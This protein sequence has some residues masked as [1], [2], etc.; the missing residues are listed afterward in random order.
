VAGDDVGE[1]A[2][3]AA[4]P[5]PEI[6]DGDGAGLAAAAGAGDG[7]AVVGWPPAGASGRAVAVA[8]AVVAGVLGGVIQA[9]P[10]RTSVVVTRRASRLQRSATRP[11]HRFVPLTISLGS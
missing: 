10:M 11:A 3:D 8:G 7:G 2:G 5:E 6:A 9:A 4:G 1:T